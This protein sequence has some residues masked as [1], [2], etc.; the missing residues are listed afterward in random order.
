M[1]KKAILIINDG[2]GK[3]E[4]SESN[5]FLNAKTPN[6]DRL[7]SEWP[8]SLIKTY[9]LAVGLPEGQ[10]GNSEVGHMTIGSG[11][12][13]YQD[14]VKVSKAVEDDTLKDNEVLD[15][16]I[17]KSK[18]VHIFGLVS[19]G[20][21]HSHLNHIIA[22]AKIASKD[23]KVFIHVIT[24]GRDVSPTSSKNYIN[25]LIDNLNDNI[26]IATIS[27]RFYGMDRDNRWERVEQ[28]YDT[29]VNGSRKTEM[30]VLDYVDDSYKHDVTDEFLKPAA[31][32][33]YGGVEDGDGFVFA[34][35][36]SDRAREISQLIGDR[37]FMPVQVGKK[38]V[39]VA[40]MTEYSKEFPFPVMFRK[41]KPENTLSQVVSKAGLKQFHTAETEKYAHVTFFFNG[42]VE[43][44]YEGETRV[45][46][47][48]PSVETYDMKPE[49]SA[50][51]V[52][53][54]VVKAVGEEYDFIVVNF[55]NGD[56][57][58]HTG[59]YEAAVKAVEAVDRNMGKILKEAERRGYGILITADHGNCEE[60]IDKEG[61]MLTNHTVGEVYCFLKC[62]GASK[63]ED[64]GLNNIAPT[65]LKMME[66]EIPKEMD[67]PLF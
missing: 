29:I 25:Q 56:M 19:D 31:F 18:R 43:E 67:K 55:A 21:V 57:V 66:L 11:R 10:M 45:L 46:I 33:G 48:S 65:I 36:R 52:G 53:D 38:D 22:L 35:F 7:F 24:D 63:V 58:G 8:N 2:I 9:G 39:H 12:V 34:N 41:K 23:K 15:E 20:G 64:G 30:S 54:A 51:E 26:E 6:F 16:L 61:N 37:E 14:L 40:T 42:G 28:C 44:P 59:N 3:K 32:N 1:S 50:D 5:A 47:P 4:P 62:D 60:M 27:G 17:S 49:M 13:S